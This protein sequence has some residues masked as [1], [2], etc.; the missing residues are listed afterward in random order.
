MVGMV[1]EPVV[2]RVEE[3]AIERFADAIDDPNPLYRDVEYAKKS[4]YGGLIAPLGFFGWPLKGKRVGE[5]IDYL[6]VIA[7]H[8]GL[9]QTLDGGNEY[10]YFLPVRAGDILTCYVKITDIVERRGREG[11]QMVLVILETRYLNQNGD[12]VAIARLTHI[13]R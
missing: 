2:C 7:E 11:K 8:L 3:G 6:G 1:S 4:R 10:E 5:E 13:V 9:T 12:L